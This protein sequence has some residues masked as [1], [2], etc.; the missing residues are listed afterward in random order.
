MEQRGLVEPDTDLD[1]L[2]EKGCAET[3]AEAAY[4]FCVHEPGADVVLTG[5]GHEQHLEANIAAALK[6]PLPSEAL[7]RLE[8]LFGDVDSVT[9]N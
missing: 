4:R 3:L 9:G 7:E 5:T 8:S 6:P 1:F 2:T